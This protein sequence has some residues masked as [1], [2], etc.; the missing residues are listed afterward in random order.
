MPINILV[1][2]FQKALKMN[3]WLLEYEFPLNN[4]IKV[5]NYI[6]LINER[7]IEVQYNQPEGI[8]VEHK[9]SDGKW[10]VVVDLYING[11]KHV[12]F[13]HSDEIELI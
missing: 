10:W 13:F 11:L 6:I 8:V 5:L 3:Q 9:F 2:L 12:G 7:G 1:Y 4:K